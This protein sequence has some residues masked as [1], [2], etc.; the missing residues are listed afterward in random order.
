MMNAIAIAMLLS[1]VGLAMVLSPQ[2]IHVMSSSD[3]ENMLKLA[4]EVV[5]EPLL[6]VEETLVETK[7]ALVKGVEVVTKPVEK[8]MGWFRRKPKPH[9]HLSIAKEKTNL[10]KE[11]MHEASIE[12]KDATLE[13]LN[14]AT[15]S[16]M[17]KST[18]IYHETRKTNYFNR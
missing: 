18:S 7:D 10:A 15:Q 11:A 16:I 17:D 5:E 8:S 14:S 4:K 12:L 13:N 2:S 3:G 6:K 9:D 1:T